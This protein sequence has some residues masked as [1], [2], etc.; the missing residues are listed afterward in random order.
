[1]YVVTGAWCGGWRT[2]STWVV[3]T[4]FRIHNRVEVGSRRIPGGYCVLRGLMTS[5]LSKLCRGIIIIANPYHHPR[6]M[7]AYSN[8]RLR[9]QL[10]RL[11]SKFCAPRGGRFEQTP[12]SVSLK[13]SQFC[14]I[15]GLTL[16]LQWRIQRW[17][18]TLLV[19]V[20]KWKHL[21]FPSGSF[22]KS[23]FCDI[24]TI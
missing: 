5:D 8:W 6:E 20:H 24:V 4:M 16:C 9:L 15:C 3:P 18:H 14:L 19:Y 23:W 17:G 12:C 7:L 2:S 22:W 13:I 21:T 10:N 11:E 1:M